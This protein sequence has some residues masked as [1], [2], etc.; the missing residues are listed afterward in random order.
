MIPKVYK[1]ELQLNVNILIDDIIRQAAHFV[2]VSESSIC[3]VIRDYKATHILKSPKKVKL[4]RNA[5]RRK[6]RHFFSFAM[7]C[8]VPSY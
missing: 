3:H 2:G 7:C 5:V 8:L 4:E 1:T 6:V